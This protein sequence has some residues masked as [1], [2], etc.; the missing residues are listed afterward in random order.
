ML[1]ITFITGSMLVLI[2]YGTARETTFQG[3]GGP[4]DDRAKILERLRTR[5]QDVLDQLHRNDSGADT[6]AMQKEIAELL[7][8]L[9]EQDDP[10]PRNPPHAPKSLP[11]PEPKGSPPSPIEKA[12][13]MQAKAVERRETE[14]APA[15]FEDMKKQLA[16]EGYWPLKL[17]ARHQINIEVSGGGRFMPRYEEL[18]RAYYRTIAESKRSDGDK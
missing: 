2:G 8:R 1:R 14:R 3:A 5:Y 10:P 17:P 6:L 16:K 11:M 18:L 13:P 4:N 12:Q 15:S 9:L 7:K